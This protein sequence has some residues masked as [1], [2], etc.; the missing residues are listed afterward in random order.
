MSLFRLAR[1]L[2][3]LIAAALVLLTALPATAQ[4]PKIPP[5]ARGYQTTMILQQHY[6]NQASKAS[7]LSPAR[8]APSSPPRY[9][10]SSL[11]VNV[12]VP[13]APMP[14]SAPVTYIT[15]RGPEGEVRRFPLA[16]GVEVVYRRGQIVLRP[17][18]STSIRLTPMY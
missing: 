17:G 8:P 16:R 18:E 1:A 7:V 10:A 11:T 14:A 15:I 13:D 9:S 4:Q 5:D 3:S 2:L 12:N 6:Q